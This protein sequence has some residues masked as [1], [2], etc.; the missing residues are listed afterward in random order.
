MRKIHY[1]TIIYLHLI[2]IGLFVNCSPGSGNGPLLFPNGFGSS[3]SSHD[4]IKIV[5][6]H[7]V[8]GSNEVV[9]GY[10]T[11]ATYADGTQADVTSNTNWTTSLPY[12]IASDGS[13]HLAD[14]NT[15]LNSTITGTVDGVTDTFHLS[16]YYG[17]LL[18]FQSNAD[19]ADQSTSCP[20]AIGTSIYLKDN[21]DSTFTWTDYSYQWNPHTATGYCDPTDATC[22]L[23][24]IIIPG[25]NLS[26]D[27]IILED[28]TIYMDFTTNNFTGSVI[29]NGTPAWVGVNNPPCRGIYSITGFI[30]EQDDNPIPH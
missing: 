20:V 4:Q 8:S 23:L 3:S 10:T 27:Q 12:T 1:K 19:P 6:P 15:P 21:Q 9:S 25:H 30:M 28:A 7:V 29:I 24:K 17:A 11:L 18:N 5:H 14:S 26:N 13:L 16:G 22:S 2:S